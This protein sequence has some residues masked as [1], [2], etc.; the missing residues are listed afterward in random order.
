MSLRAFTV[1]LPPEEVEAL[2]REA[3]EN[4]RSGSSAQIRFIL[5][6]RRRE[7]EAQRTA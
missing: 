3:E 2:D 4:G 5:L 1:Y 7:L 6:Q